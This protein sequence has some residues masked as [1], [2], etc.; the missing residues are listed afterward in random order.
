MGEMEISGLS[1]D[2]YIKKNK[3]G[4]QGGERRQRRD[5]GIQ[6]PKVHY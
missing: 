5:G 4:R 6:K 3:G 1:L 2:D